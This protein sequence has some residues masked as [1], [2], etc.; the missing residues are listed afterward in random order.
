M[1]A[2]VEMA[3]AGLL[4]LGGL[5]GLI[6]SYGLLRLQDRMQRLHAP[7]KATTLGVGTALV[8]LAFQVWLVED[9]L[10]WREVLVALFFLATAPLSALYLAK[11][12]LHRE[13]PKSGLPATG[14][15]ADW[16]SFA[17]DPAE[18]P[19]GN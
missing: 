5:L 17:P 7:T 15:G 4:V 1:T 8:G 9:R 12:H 19:A 11:A 6:G 2:L 10:A 18:P 16:G 3:V 14:T 13:G